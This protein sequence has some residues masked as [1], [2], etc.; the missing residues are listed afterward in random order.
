MTTLNRETDGYVPVSDSP[1]HGLQPEP[2]E[3]N[4]RWTY[5]HSRPVKPAG[6]VSPYRSSRDRD[7]SAERAR[8]ENDTSVER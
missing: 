8:V 2:A 3:A 1:D 6:Y 7:L 4:R 5:H